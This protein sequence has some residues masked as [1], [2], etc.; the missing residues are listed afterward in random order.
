MIE[1]DMS[2]MKNNKYKGIKVNEG[3]KGVRDVLE[4]GDADLNGG[5]V[6]ALDEFVHLEGRRVRVKDDRTQ[7]TMKIYEHTE[8]IDE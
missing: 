4:L 3:G 7:N 8:E 1:N 5:L 2:N 6:A